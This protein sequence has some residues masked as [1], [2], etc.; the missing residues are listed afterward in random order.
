MLTSIHPH[1]DL[2][3]SYFDSRKIVNDSRPWPTSFL[4][5]VIDHTVCQVRGMGG[6]LQMWCGQQCYV[7]ASSADALHAVCDRRALI[8]KQ[9]TQQI[10]VIHVHRRLRLPIAGMRSSY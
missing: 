10:Y 6:I 7:I 9:N 4:C 8:S 5:N 1:Y 3:L 2:W